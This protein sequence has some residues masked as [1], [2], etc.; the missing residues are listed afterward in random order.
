MH[1]AS[2]DFEVS[3]IHPR[4]WAAAAVNALCFQN[5]LLLYCHLTLT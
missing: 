4:L 2:F 3:L 5:D 1:F